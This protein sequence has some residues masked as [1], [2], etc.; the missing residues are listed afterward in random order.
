MQVGRITGLRGQGAADRACGNFADLSMLDG[1]TTIGELCEMIRCA[2][3]L[4]RKDLA[5]I[6]NAT[7]ANVVQ[8]WP[9]TARGSITPATSDVCEWLDNAADNIEE[10]VG[11][12]DWVRK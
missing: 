8:N 6:L 9:R 4:T 12:S 7:A 11:L 2:G 5:R 3:P 10:G 1:Q